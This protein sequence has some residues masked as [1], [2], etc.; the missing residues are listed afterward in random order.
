MP[1][2]TDVGICS[3]YLVIC[4]HH[5]GKGDK[6]HCLK[7]DHHGQNFL[8]WAEYKTKQ[9]KTYAKTWKKQQQNQ[10]KENRVQK[11]GLKWSH[12]GLTLQGRVKFHF[13][14]FLPGIVAHTYQP[15]LGMP[16]QSV[17]K[18]LYNLIS[19]RPT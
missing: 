7:R 11:L 18:C 13:C 17:L 8:E 6:K 16:R 12:W 14:H 19:L 4:R 2:C 15:E 1:C 5:L 10:T 3:H 9:T